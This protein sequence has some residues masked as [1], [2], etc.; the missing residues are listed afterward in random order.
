[1]KKCLTA[2][3]NVLLLFALSPTALHAQD[4][5]TLEERFKAR[6]FANSQ[7]TL[8]AI[9]Q[10]AMKAKDPNF[11][12]NY[13][14]T[15]QLSTP[16]PDF[17]LP[18]ELS[19]SLLEMRLAKRFTIFK[20]T[21]SRSYDFMLLSKF[22]VNFDF[23]YRVGKREDSDIDDNPGL[24]LNTKFGVTLFEHAFVISGK[25]KDQK[26]S[27]G[28][29]SSAWGKFRKEKKKWYVDPPNFSTDSIGSKFFNQKTLKMLVARADLMHY[30]NGQDS[31]AFVY[32][33]SLPVRNDY[34]S[35]NF[36]TNYSHVMLSFIQVTNKNQLLDLTVGLRNDFQLTKW[37]TYESGQEERYGICR[38]TTVI[39]YRTGPVNLFGMKLRDRAFIQKKREIK[40]TKDN[41]EVMQQQNIV[42][43]TAQVRLQKLEKSP[44]NYKTLKA[45]FDWSFTFSSEHILDNPELLP[46][47]RSSFSFETELV[48]LYAETVGFTL[49][50]YYGRDYLNI[51]YDLPVFIWRFGL[52]FQIGRYRPSYE[53]IR[54]NMEFKKT[55]QEMK[56]K[57]S[58]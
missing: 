6:Y 8:Y 47:N 4:T 16:I 40:Q 37:L 53:S 35:G 45:L 39:H 14:S 55:L 54:N 28:E 50:A 33:P 31:G 11:Y 44:S 2:F 38:L 29:P 48:P 24:P 49:A 30:S 22:S 26:A 25:R 18:E 15:H 10:Q 17:R 7:N 9:V 52:T 32:T 34:I 43:D 58:M 13:I 1:M 46:D 41:I 57:Q 36:S 42:T 12:F 3:A 21:D 27:S 23:V 56:R 5:T 20:G 51:R 19:G